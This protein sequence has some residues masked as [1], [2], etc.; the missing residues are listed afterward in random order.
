MGFFVDE[1]AEAIMKE[2]A[3]IIRENMAKARASETVKE[4]LKLAR[5]TQEQERFA[6]SPV[7]K[8]L[9]ASVGASRQV[10]QQL[11]RGIGIALKQRP[12]FSI[13]QQQLQQMFGGGDKIWGTN[14]E[15]VVLYN[16]LNPGRSNPFDE[17]AGMF[18]FGMG[19][20]RS[21]LF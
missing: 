21:G 14:R 4:N 15:P 8:S 19:G 10:G 6:G 13:E 12:D 1:D 20:E 2:E 16:D 17:T 9:S 11:G 18:G 3:R 5:I 7:G